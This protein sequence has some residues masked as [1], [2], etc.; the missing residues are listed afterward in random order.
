MKTIMKMKHEEFVDWAAGRILT[1]LIR[2]DFRSAVWM[3]VDQAVRR[4]ENKK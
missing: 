4:A 3:V 2:G 1:A